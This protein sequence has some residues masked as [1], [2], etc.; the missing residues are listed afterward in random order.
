VCIQGI[1]WKYTEAELGELVGECGEVEK[2]EVMTSPDGRS[3]VGQAHQIPLT[4]P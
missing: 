3:K 4:R 2:S 1:P